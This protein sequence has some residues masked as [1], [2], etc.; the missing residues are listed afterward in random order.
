M[1]RINAIKYESIKKPLPKISLNG[2]FSSIE[3]NNKKET[4]HNDEINN[5]RN[6]KL[7]IKSLNIIGFKKKITNII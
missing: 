2:L 4:F 3:F 6:I 1:I 7:P 5:R